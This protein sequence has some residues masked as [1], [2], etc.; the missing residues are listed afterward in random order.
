MHVVL[1]GVRVGSLRYISK[2]PIC[3]HGLLTCT[4]PVL[5]II[6]LKHYLYSCIYRMLVSLYVYT[7]RSRVYV[8]A[9]FG[10]ELPGFPTVSALQQALSAANSMSMCGHPMRAKTSGALL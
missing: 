9:A 8:L 1:C 6:Y 10:H 5:V 4:F 3:I 7:G 2:K